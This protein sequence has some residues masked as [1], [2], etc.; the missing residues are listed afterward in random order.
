MR[1]YKK[2][3]LAAT[4]LVL[5]SADS[6][7]KNTYILAKGY[8]VSIHGTSNLHDWDE[9]VNNVSGESSVSWSS[10]TSFDLTA[11]NIKMEVKSIKSTEGSMMNNNTYKA[12]KADDHP[13]IVFALATQLPGIPVDAKGKVIAAK[14]NLSIAGVTKTV[15]MS[16]TVT[17]V[18]HGNIAFEGSKTIKM[19]DY[20]VKPPVAMLGT[21][22]TGDEITIHF[23]TVFA[24]KQ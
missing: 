20:G 6:P 23:K 11:M 5:M 4:A 1:S 22:K 15:D 19:T 17:A 12:L 18:S 13:E 21:M 3:L 2:L 9:R 24:V 10:N 14:V 8:T 7:V 16:V